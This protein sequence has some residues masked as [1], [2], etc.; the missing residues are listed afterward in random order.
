MVANDIVNEDLYN[1]LELIL[2]TP[3]PEEEKP[4]ML[5][6]AEDLP[7]TMGLSVQLTF[8]TD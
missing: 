8:E 4:E 7:F 6:T 3:F 5:L 2:L 1:I